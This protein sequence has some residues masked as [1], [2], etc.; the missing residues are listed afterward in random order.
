M[1]LLST[2][3]RLSIPQEAEL[4]AAYISLTS[5]D[6]SPHPDNGS[7]EELSALTPSR[8]SACPS[9]L[10]IIKTKCISYLVTEK[11]YMLHTHNSIEEKR[12]PKHDSQ[13]H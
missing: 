12:S 5:N 3:D 4:K 1:G 11:S 7:V 9:T 13:N 2:Q 10:K 6:E 8:Y